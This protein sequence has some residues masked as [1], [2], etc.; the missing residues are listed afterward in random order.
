MTQAGKSWYKPWRVACYVAF[1]PIAES[2]IICTKYENFT[3]YVS[4]HSTTH[5]PISAKGSET[6]QILT[7]FFFLEKRIFNNS[8]ICFHGESKHIN[9]K[10][11]SNIDMGDACFSALWFGILDLQLNIF[12]LWIF[13]AYLI[14]IVHIQYHIFLRIIVTDSLCHI[15]IAYLIPHIVF[16]GHR[17]QQCYDNKFRTI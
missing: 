5:N 12:V 7:A 4:N 1:I 15:H 10:Y 16:V 17:L 6:C 3:W 11:V 2:R 14:C 13:Y 9:I 8:Q